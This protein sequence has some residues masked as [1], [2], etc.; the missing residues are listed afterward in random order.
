M[1]TEYAHT[2]TK[3]EVE[4]LPM[5]KFEGRIFVLTNEKEANRA[6]DYLERYPVLGFD[7]ETRPNFRRG[8]RNKIALVQLSTEDTCFL[9]RLNRMGFPAS[10][11]KLL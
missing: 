9:F 8:K 1:N 2:I 6:V 7:T 3:E 11:K 10:L 4:E 5:E